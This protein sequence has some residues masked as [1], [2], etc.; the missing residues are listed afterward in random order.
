MGGSLALL[1]LLMLFG[2][3]GV[4]ALA[5]ATQT[6]PPRPPPRKPPPAPPTA[7]RPGPSAPPL[8]QTAARNAE[9][10]A[11]TQPRPFPQAVPSGLP[12][13]PGSGW[14]ADNPPPPAVVTR[15]WQLLPILWAGG[16]P[17][18]FKVEQTGGRWIAYLAQDHGGGKKGVTAFKLKNP[19]A[20]PATPPLS[21][22]PPWGGGG[23]AKPSPQPAPYN[24][25]RPP[26]A[27]NPYPLPGVV[28]AGYSV[29]AGASLRQG[30]GMG[31]LA[32][33]A[34]EV[35]KVQR[36]LGITADGKFGPGTKA[37]VVAFQKKNGLTADGIV[38]PQ[39]RAKLGVAA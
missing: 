9:A 20:L 5:P 34:P 26:S 37:A 3:G 29:P 21:D 24:A 22:S 11:N 19:N 16:K 4:P 1:V 8:Q 13:F 7:S 31:A 35:A 17:G 12:P 30:S 10:K 39:T 18:N 15:A 27:S 32:S 38:G 23:S 33:Q 28:P 25:S 36:A 2:G 14:T 6:R